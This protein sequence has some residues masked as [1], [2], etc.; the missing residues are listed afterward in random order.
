METNIDP[1]QTR[2]ELEL[3]LLRSQIALNMAQ[4]VLDRKPFWWGVVPYAIAFAVAAAVVATFFGFFADLYQISVTDRE[5]LRRD[6]AELEVR[7]KSLSQEATASARKDA[8]IKEYQSRL[9][10]AAV[11]AT[12]PSGFGVATLN[13]SQ[14]AG[15]LLVASWGNASKELLVARLNPI[16]AKWAREP[17]AHGATIGKTEYS[18]SRTDPMSLEWS[19]TW[20]Y[21]A[22]K[23][24]LKE[25]HPRKFDHA[26]EIHIDLS[27]RTESGQLPATRIL[28]ASV[29][30]GVAV[31]LTPPDG[32]KLKR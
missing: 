3:E 31:L 32:L 15:A 24:S 13:A 7:L 14:V 8:T 23:V 29:E 12:E 22:G 25:T 28:G 17:F 2:P 6:K 20:T 16:E 21:S 26:P 1:P 19:G 27:H 9:D 5:Q 18:K 4:A 10:A 11:C 30:N